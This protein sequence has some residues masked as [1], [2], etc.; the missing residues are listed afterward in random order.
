MSALQHESVHV[1]TMDE[2]REMLPPGDREDYDRERAE[3][4]PRTIAEV[5]DKWWGFALL[6]RR[7]GFAEL[8][9]ETA[10]TFG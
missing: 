10:R 8:A 4:T 9:E 6:Y 7:P 2:I 5:A 1:P 3:A